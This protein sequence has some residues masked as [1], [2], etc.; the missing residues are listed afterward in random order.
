MKKV[1]ILMYQDI[2]YYQPE[3]SFKKLWWSIPT[4][5]ELKEYGFSKEDAKSLE[6]ETEFEYDS[7][8]V[9]IQKNRVKDEYYGVYY[10]F[11]IYTEE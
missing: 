4:Y 9:L 2:D 5:K 11:E 8:G 1:W 7:L 3:K 10:W 6:K